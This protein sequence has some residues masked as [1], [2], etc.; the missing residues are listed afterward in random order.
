M[1]LTASWCDLWVWGFD[2]ICPLV[3]YFL[4][5]DFHFYTCIYNVLHMDRISCCNVKKSWIRNIIFLVLNRRF[6]VVFY[7]LNFFR[8][9]IPYYG[10]VGENVY[11][12]VQHYKKGLDGS[13]SNGVYLYGYICP[14]RFQYLPCVTGIVLLSINRTILWWSNNRNRHLYTFL[15]FVHLVLEPKYSGLPVRADCVVKI[16]ESIVLTFITVTS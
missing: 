6:G 4:H 15:L 8:F 5:V 16:S 2:I 10:L 7:V 1:R 3:F 9:G 13:K 11:T 12:P 14:Q